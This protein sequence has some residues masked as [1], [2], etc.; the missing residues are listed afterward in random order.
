MNIQK[1]TEVVCLSKTDGKMPQYQ[2]KLLT[3]IWCCGGFDQNEFYARRACTVL[4]PKFVEK[5]SK[6]APSMFPCQQD[7]SRFAA[8]IGLSERRLSWCGIHHIEFHYFS[9]KKSLEPLITHSR[10]IFSI[11]CNST[12]S[13]PIDQV[14]GFLVFHQTPKFG[15]KCWYARTVFSK[16][17]HF[18]AP[19]RWI[20]PDSV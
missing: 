10:K 9:L 12:Y 15:K 13:V 20:F 19:F 4:E 16:C 6:F 2:P 18:V 1:P 11:S 17:M 3:P 14:I 8:P 5:S 7:L